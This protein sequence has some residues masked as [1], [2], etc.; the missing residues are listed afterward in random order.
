MKKDA[1]TILIVAIFSAVLSIILSGL[2]IS[3]PEDR[4]QKVEVVDPIVTTFEAPSK[5]YFNSNSVNPSQNIQIGTDSNSNPFE[6][7]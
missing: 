1:F 5:E 2:F 4:A 6:V 3:T 7:R